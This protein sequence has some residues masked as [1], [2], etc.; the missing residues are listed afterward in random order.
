MIAPDRL[1][2]FEIFFCWD[3][4]MNFAIFSETD[5]RIFHFFSRLMDEFHDFFSATID[6]FHNI[7]KWPTGEFLD[8]F[9]TIDW[10]ILR[11]FLINEWWFSQFFFLQSMN[12]TTFYFLWP[13]GEIQCFLYDWCA[14][15]VVFFPWPINKFH[16]FFPVH[17]W[18]IC[19]FF[20]MTYCWNSQDFFHVI[21][22][23]IW[24]FF[25][26]TDRRILQFFFP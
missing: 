15:F 26:M 9:P 11:F 22:G 20:S 5:W 10:Q 25:P 21:N 19:R 17:S 6:K 3:R 23:W 1:M 12:F 16:D 8:N 24:W 13:I 4:S 7:L 18:G 2:N 14:N